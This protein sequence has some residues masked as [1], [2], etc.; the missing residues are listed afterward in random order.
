MPSFI[1][2]K[3]KTFKRLLLNSYLIP[4]CISFALVG[5]YI[6]P[7]PDLLMSAGNDAASIWQT[8]TTF[9]SEK[10]T[11]SYVLYKGFLSVYPYIWFLELS[12]FLKLDPFFFIKIYHA[13]LFSFVA[14]I[15]VPYVVSRILAVEIKLYKN[16]IFV[17]ILF[18]LVEFTGIFR[19][20]MVDLPSWAF[21]VA[22]LYFLLLSFNSNKIV[23]IP[24]LFIGGIA[25]GLTLSASGQ[26]SL[27]GYIIIV[28]VAVSLL[29]RSA[30]F[31]RR[32]GLTLFLFISVF[33]TGIIIPKVYDVHFNKTI[34]QPMRN[35]G[36][37][38]PTGA[39]WLSYGLTPSIMRYKHFSN[40]AESNRG[41]AILK[42]IE[43]DNF[44]KRYEQIRQGVGAYSG[45]E[46]VNIILSD[47]INFGLLL[48]N[49][50][51]LA[52]SYDDAKNRV[53]HLIFSYTALFICSYLLLVKLRRFRDLLNVNVLIIISILLTIAA[54][55]LLHIEARY[56][57]SLIGFILGFAV[58]QNTLT[59]KLKE[60]FGVVK[61]E[62]AERGYRHLKNSTIPYPMIAY[63]IFLIFSFT[64]Y[65]ALL[66]IPGSDPEKVLY[67]W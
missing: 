42:R 30:G 24:M 53:S 14:A 17:S 46:Y 12:I 26:Y 51:F 19:M 32:K 6:F 60:Y 66:E 45:A 15:G 1:L 41:L 34:V 44:D 23:R 59:S 35:S 39:Q 22:A 50:A 55:M 25:V 47:P 40:P 62:G 13:L 31:V 48:V 52:I 9:R 2:L 64:L 18:Y 56:S 3:N 21:F 57:V 65:G 4:F 61:S 27:S 10:I 43:G 63:V 33:C 49:K 7:L 20:L 5:F 58:H 28:Y 11:S 67:R 37:W 29:M 36:E 8:I 54:P 16:I 38:L